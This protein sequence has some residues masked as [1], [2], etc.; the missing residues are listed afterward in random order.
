MH[1]G[2]TEASR[3]TFLEFNSERDK[4]DTVGRASPNV[5]VRISD[6]YGGLLGPN[7]QGEIVVSGDHV[8]ERYYEDKALNQCSFLQDGYFRTGD[9]G[10]I[11]DDGYVRLLGRNDDM[12]NMGGIKISPL[13]VEQAISNVF[14][15]IEVCVLGI[16]SDLVGEIPVV[17]YVR[18]TNSACLDLNSLTN[19]LADVLD[20]NKLPRRVIEVDSFPKTT[21]GKVIRKL[22]RQKLLS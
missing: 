14:S 5:N 16:P 7:E 13:E 10:V 18:S 1:Y 3:S 11:D 15:D 2:L 9:L 12:I 6:S 22:L 8:T 21:N 20:K 19:T 4:L 17:V